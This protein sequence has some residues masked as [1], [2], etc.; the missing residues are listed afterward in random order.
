MAGLPMKAH[1]R[2][3]EPQIDTPQWS[4]SVIRKDISVIAKDLQEW[5]T[6]RLVGYIVGLSD[7]R[8]I[9]RYARKE[10][11]PQSDR[12]RH[13]R[14]LYMLVQRMREREDDQTIQAWFVGRNL[15]L[16]EQAPAKL[17]RTHFE[18]R[19]SEVSEAVHQ[20]LTG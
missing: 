9:G 14:D 4:D 2:H 15:F 5:L 11:T 16:G 10:T 3:A 20:F 1:V 19:F 17:L 8:D 18:S 13:L 7:A 12:A 6:Q